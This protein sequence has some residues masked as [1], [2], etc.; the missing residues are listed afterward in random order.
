MSTGKR[1]IA[2]IWWQLRRGE[3]RLVA[4]SLAYST[5]L[6][7]IPFLA[8]TLAI[9][10]YIGGLEVLY[11][12]V[13]A[14]ILQ[15]FKETAGIEAATLIKK[16]LER[17]QTKAFGTTAAFALIFTSWRLLSDIET[18]IQRMWRKRSKRPIFKRIFRTWLLLLFFPLGLSVYFGFRSMS[19]VKPFVKTYTS[20]LDLLVFFL[21]L[22]FLYKIIPENK[23]KNTAAAIGALSASIGIL[24]LKSSFT[25]ITQKAF[26]MNKFYGSLAAIPLLLLWILMMW[27]IVL[28]GVAVTSGY[29]KGIRRNAE[30]EIIFEP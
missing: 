30:R 24:I 20:V 11:P 26:L 12:K 23:V 15:S 28:F 7:L 16:I 1:L 25:W 5:M 9:F 29:Q 14:F 18:G 27:Y 3:I 2:D 22:L 17:V 10:K 19:L 4:G 21:M 6:S 13:Q 8:L